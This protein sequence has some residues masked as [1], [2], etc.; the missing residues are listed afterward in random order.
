[1]LLL[2]AV[3]MSAQEVPTFFPRKFLMEHFTS[4]NCYQCPE[5]MQTIVEYLKNPNA[6][7]I[8]VSHH[9]V[10]GEDAYTIPESNEIAQEHLIY[11]VP[12]VMINRTQQEKQL[13]LD[14]N[15]LSTLQV[16]D[17][18]L[19][20]ASIVIE[21]TYDSI[22]RRLNLTVTGQVASAE[23]T[24]YLLTIL[25]KENRLVSKQA[26]QITS[27]KKANWLEYMHSRVVRDVVT[28][29][30][31]DTVEVK[32]QTYSYS[33]RY[34]INKN[35]IADNCC[36]VAYLTPLSHRPIINAEQ[37]A[38]VRGTTGGEQ[39]EP[40]G[41][42]EA[43]GPSTNL[44]FDNIQ[45]KRINEQLLELQL[46]ANKTM[47]SYA[48]ICKPVSLLYVNTTASV[49]EPGTYA[50]QSGSELGTL[51]AGYR[52]DEEETFG[53]S[54]LLYALSSDLKNGRVTPI[55]TWRINTGQMV[56]KQD[57]NIALNFTTYN[58][59]TVTAT[60]LYDFI[61]ATG[62]EDVQESR[63]LDVQKILQDGQ[64]VIKKGEVR[65]TVLGYRL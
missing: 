54:R 55:H 38:L 25:I 52:I 28:A 62:L 64:L 18:T 45:V 7:Y 5:G 40:Y 15:R 9:A 19:A 26:D 23:T 31:G 58:G 59:T 4:E 32:N 34:T 33:K 44:T 11:H 37:V 63:R 1:M 2:A 13:V 16:A 43:Q 48:G 3:K 8:W 22:N 57:G 30:L 41:I 27:W 17:D 29:T 20:E 10:F 53:G 39:Y 46:M 47:S 24:K 61:P 6:P 12:T 50:I 35:W 14:A 51:T 42:T 36:I 65:Y 60:A 49:L 21:H 56:L